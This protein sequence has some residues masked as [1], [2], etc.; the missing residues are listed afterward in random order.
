[1]KHLKKLF[2]TEDGRIFFVMAVS[3]VVVYAVKFLET[4]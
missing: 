4:L 1:M 2:T 3:V